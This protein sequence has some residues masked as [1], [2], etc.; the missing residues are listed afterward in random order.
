MRK[1]PRR[2]I[3]DFDFTVALAFPVD[4]RM[5]QCVSQVNQRLTNQGLLEIFGIP[6][7]PS[8]GTSEEE[9]DGSRMGA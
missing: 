4:E 3:E 6:P 8:R 1:Q 9:L 7:I 5:R 2:V